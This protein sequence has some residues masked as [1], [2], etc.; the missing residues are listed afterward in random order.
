MERTPVH[1]IL[2]DATAL[3]GAA[4]CATASPQLAGKPS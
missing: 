2:N 4:I 1:V 3:M